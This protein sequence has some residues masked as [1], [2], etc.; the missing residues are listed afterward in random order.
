MDGGACYLAGATALPTSRASR[1]EPDFN[2][3]Q[4]YCI[5]FYTWCLLGAGRWV[6]GMWGCLGR[7]GRGDGMWG[8][9]ACCVGGGMVLRRLGC[10]FSGGEIAA[11]ASSLDAGSAWRSPPD[12]RD[13]RRMAAPC[14]VSLDNPPS[15]AGADEDAGV[16]CGSSA[17]G[18]SAIAA[19]GRPIIILDAFV[20][21]DP[22]RPPA[23][24]SSNGSGGGPRAV[25]GRQGPVIPRS[26]EK[27]AGGSKTRMRGR[28]VREA[29]PSADPSA[30]CSATPPLPCRDVLLR[31]LRA[32]AGG[33]TS[34][35]R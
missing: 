11:P 24:C 28:G 27:V 35:G 8:G 30:A 15:A 18:E 23:L 25:S 12:R 22:D 4:I 26:A 14:A 20:A 2:G 29:V 9:A 5:I 33:W 3:G 16:A 17:A 6:L 1:L 7:G 13:V 32:S 10:S 31:G 21:Q 19:A 34:R